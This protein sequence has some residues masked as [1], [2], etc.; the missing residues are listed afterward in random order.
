MPPDVFFRRRRLQSLLFFAVIGALTYGSIVI[1]QFDVVQGIAAV[2]R[3]FVWAVAN[4]IPDE[5]AWSRLPR[6]LEK[7]QETV[8]VSIAASTVAALF[9]LGL[10]LLGANTTRPPSMV[11]PAGARIGQY[12]SQYRCL[13]LGAHPALFVRAERVHRFF[14]LVL[15]DFRLHHSRDD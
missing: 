1:T 2:P 11:E 12:L 3:A 14:R 7:L 4:F 9:G 6:I 15:C 8:L 5:R 13:G 10:A